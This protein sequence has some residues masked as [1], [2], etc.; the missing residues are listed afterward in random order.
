MSFLYAEC[1]KDKDVILKAN[2]RTLNKYPLLRTA[3]DYRSLFGVET[4]TLDRHERD[5]ISAVFTQIL[6]EEAAMAYLDRKVNELPHGEYLTLEVIKAV[7]EHVHQEYPTLY[8]GG[9]PYNIVDID[10]EDRY[11][12][13]AE[14]LTT[15]KALAERYVHK[16]ALTGVI[17]SSSNDE[18]PVDIPEDFK[19]KKWYVQDTWAKETE[20]E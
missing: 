5:G 3:D 10:I 6:E 20:N 18:L 19:V 14:E 1:L 2:R 16:I 11:W 13:I 17:R 4:F 15:E 7:K 12:D 9:E 8:F